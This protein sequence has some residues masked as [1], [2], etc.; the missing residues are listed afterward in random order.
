MRLKS[1]KI[2]GFKSFVDP[3]TLSFTSNL[4]AIVGPNGCGKSNVIDAVRWVMGES[5][6]KYLRGENMTDVIFNGS[7]N[8]QPLGQASIE[9]V[10]DNDSGQLGGAYAN[11]AELSV[12]RLVTRDATSSYFLNGSRCRRKDIT[13]IFLGTGLG[14][15]SYAIIEQGMISR[16][17]EARPEELRVYLEEAANISKYKD[18]RRETQ[19]RIQ[20]TEE[21]LE[22]LGDIL[23]ELNKQLERLGRQASAAKQYQQL[24]KSERILKAEL[25][26]LRWQ[27]A[28]KQLALRIEDIKNQELAQ[29]ASLVKLRQEENQLETSRTKQ[30]EASYQL[31]SAQQQLTQLSMEIARLEQGLKHRISRAQQLKQEVSQLNKEQATTHST[32]TQDQQARDLLAAELEE[33]EPQLADEE[34]AYQA[35]RLQVSQL[36]E[37]LSQLNLAGQSQQAA[38]ADNQR[39]ADLAAQRIHQG[40]HQLARLQQQL[41]DLLTQPVSQEQLEILT[42]Q[43]EE[44]ALTEAQLEENLAQVETSSQQTQENL[45]A[46]ELQLEEISAQEKQ[47]SQRLQQQQAR[48]TSLQTLQQAEIQ[49]PD[50]QVEAWLEQ[51]GIADWAQLGSSLQ[52]QVGWEKPLELVLAG[53]LTSFLSPAPLDNRLLNQ[54]S[55]LPAGQLWLLQAATANQ[56]LAINPNTLLSK[57]TNPEILPPSLAEWLNNFLIAPSL[58]TAMQQQEQLGKQ[59]AFITQKGEILYPDRLLL[60]APNAPA[61]GFLA[62]QTAISQL[63]A[64]NEEL[65]LQLEELNE[66]LETLKAEQTQLKAQLNELNLSTRPLHTQLAQLASKK[67]SLAT[68]VSHQQQLN[69]QL[70]KQKANLA[71]EKA[72]L[73]EQLEDDL[74]QLEEAQLKQAATEEQL[75]EHQQAVNQLQGQLLAAKET[76]EASSQ[77]VQTSR[78]KY[79]QLSTQQ[80]ASQ[81]ALARLEQLA[82]HQAEKL[83]QLELDLASAEEP[84]NEQEE[85]LNQLLNQ[86]LTQNEQVDKLR[87]IQA[88]AQEEQRQL[89]QQR[90]ASDQQ[91]NQH[92]QRLEALRLE[93]QSLMHKRDTHLEVLNELKL[94]LHEVLTDLN[95]AA[96]ET[97]WET[98]LL[99]TQNKIQRLGAINL[100]AIDEYDQ[101]AER[102]D[103]LAAQQQELEE[104][105]ATLEGA[106]QRIDQETKQRFKA[107]FDQVNAGLQKLFP[108][109]FGGGTAWLQLTGDNLLETGV[110]IMARPPG[111]KNTSIHL[112][113]GGEKA[114]TALALVFS[115]FELNPA[116]FCMLDEVDAPLDDAN[117]GRYAQLIQE[118]SATIQFI[119]ITHNKQAMQTAHQLIGVTM[120]EPGVSRL[121]SVDLAAAEQMLS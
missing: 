61:T 58:E 26:V 55:G 8:R 1:I 85:R 90:L 91:L 53:L 87:E 117:V 56:P 84:S 78:L 18:R 69:E 79:Q 81:A 103:Y 14:P 76:L 115:I 100:A 70:I 23:L 82:H 15:R 72:Q 101:Q 16:L 97:T 83:S 42:E 30:A 29:E 43:L 73:E 37:Q 44:L 95:S 45:A 49:T 109:I 107:T 28:D 120:Q 39:L 67:A 106:I 6:A 59:Q 113:S 71:E 54:L 41:S 88:L 31:D 34:E 99:T 118:M 92:R 63:E 65:D 3:T 80:Q 12:K 75:D 2:A 102:R 50:T 40:K 46:N 25:A 68:Q 94:K 9:L 98:L 48:L 60:Q 38:K 27:Q 112:L 10:F 22:R 32:L 66:Q 5:S 89:E 114:L 20:R 21:N 111:K 33:L 86:H 17:I 62:R 11:Y 105:L 13:D 19:N 110:A 24:R 36:E 47:V 116:P 77:Q 74:M 51:Q 52:P 93:Q 108:K 57:L 64:S 121:V 104:A 7:R 4:S 96:E 35:A 119:Y